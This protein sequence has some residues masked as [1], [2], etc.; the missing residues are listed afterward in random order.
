MCG[1]W[2]YVGKE[3]SLETL[4]SVAHRGPDDFGSRSFMTP[5]GTLE[6][7]N[8]RLRILDLSPL[9]HQP[10]TYAGGRYWIVYNGEI[11]NY[12]EI[13]KDL[14][15]RGHRFRS[16]SDTEVL[17]AAYAQWGESC[18]KRFNGM[19]AFC[20]W[21]DASRKLFVARDRFGVKPLYY[22]NSSRG[23]AFASEIKQFTG[24]PSF[25]PYMNAQR[26]Y[27]FL[28]HGF[29]DHTDETLFKN[30]YQLRGGECA[31]ISMATWRP[32][33]PL[34]IK[35]WYALEQREYSQASLSE[36]AE[37][38]QEL[39]TDS[40]RLRLRSDVPVGSCLSGGMDSSS[41]VCI[42]NLLLKQGG[43]SNVQKAFSSCFDEEKYDER[44]YIKEVVSHSNADA[45][46]VFPQE[47]ELFT[48][49]EK[50]VWHYDEPFNSTSIF[51]QWNV[52]RAARENG[53]VVMLDGQG[54]DEQLGSYP[55]FY[56]PYL[57]GL[58]SRFKILKAFKEAKKLQEY[59]SWQYSSVANNLV[60]GAMPLELY[61]S[62]RRL[63]N[64]NDV[65]KWLNA[66]W[67]RS[68]GVQNLPM[69]RLIKEMNGIGR[70]SEL[71]IEM[72]LR[73][74][75]P[76]LLHWEDR[77]SMAN[78]VEA[79]VPFMDYRL[80]EFALRLPD[81]YKIHNGMTK[82]ILKEAMA[83]MVPERIRSRVDKMGFVTPEELWMKHSLHDRFQQ[84]LM[85]TCEL[86]PGLFNKAEL[87]KRFDAVVRG[88]EPFSN[89]FWRIIT[90]GVW[91]RVFKV[92]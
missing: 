83:G 64:Q 85:S 44:K 48:T 4:G 33:Q 58:A 63:R 77:S 52:F 75:I 7:A 39:L 43:S 16:E 50:L 19:F 73:T 53:V 81:D 76:M 28:A 60:S 37:K 9:G 3:S 55:Q 86:F 1:I 82:Y 38:Y 36:A 2:G 89:V 67:L 68:A 62:M 61:M 65:P 66:G 72:I 87:Q 79:R 92:V 51:A 13:R 10:M 30:V 18:L 5:A 21:D 57:L 14:E 46:Y 90:F 29:L 49:L 80:I 47:S 91:K 32:G 42:S 41:I 8:W 70:T 25:A 78:S 56:A 27:E 54:G 15:A 22:Y 35:R 11:Y 45:H 31:L 26:A 74:T 88:V 23:L 59:Q 34:P 24:L 40:V 71:S 6:L 69:W 20:L 12:K 84:E 17:L